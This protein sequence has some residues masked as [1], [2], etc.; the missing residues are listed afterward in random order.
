[1]SSGATS[2]TSL[3]HAPVNWHNIEVRNAA[4]GQPYIEPS[5]RLRELLERR[6]IRTIHLSLTDERTLACAFVVLEG[7]AA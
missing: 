5:A 4:S 7:A 2:L 3:I 1:M 6:G